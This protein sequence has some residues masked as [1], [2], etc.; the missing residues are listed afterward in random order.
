MIDP[1]A[2]TQC[3]TRITQEQINNKQKI[4]NSCMR[5]N[6]LNND[7]LLYKLKNKSD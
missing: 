6:E 5:E 3:G 7:E 1:C 4:C 2:C